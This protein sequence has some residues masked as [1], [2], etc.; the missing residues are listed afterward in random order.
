M[1][2]NQNCRWNP[3]IGP[4]VFGWGPRLRGDRNVPGRDDHPGDQCLPLLL[5]W[6]RGQRKPKSEVGWLGTS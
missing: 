4:R 3:A 2:L 1:G 6:L 5:G